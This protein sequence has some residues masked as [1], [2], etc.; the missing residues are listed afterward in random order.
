MIGLVVGV[1]LGIVFGRLVW[2]SLATSFPI[3]YSPPLALFATVLVIPVALLVANL[4]AAGPSRRA[5]R[6]QPAAVLRSE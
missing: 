3:V 5:S 1:P 4:L 6:I 2:H